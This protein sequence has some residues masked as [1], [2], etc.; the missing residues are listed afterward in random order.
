MK[1]GQY[2]GQEWKMIGADFG[3]EINLEI[4]LSYSKRKC[5]WLSTSSWRIDE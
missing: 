3:K 5:R 2:T 4:E 1:L